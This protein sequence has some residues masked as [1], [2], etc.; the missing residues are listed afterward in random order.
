SRFLGAFIVAVVL[1]GLGAVFSIAQGVLKLVHPHPLD[2]L[3]VALVI[4]A[5]AIVLESVSLRSA[6]SAARLSKQR[7][8]SWIRLI[9]STRIPELAVVLIEDS[10]ALVGLGIALVAI[11]LSAITGN[12]VFDAVG[13][14]L[15]GTLLGVNSVLL[16]VEMASLLVGESASSDELE[17]LD[18]ALATTPSITRVVHLRAVHLG[19][20]ELLVGAK[21][22]FTPGLSAEAAAAVIDE[23]EVKIRSAVPSAHWVYIE[24]GRNDGR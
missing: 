7:S 14:L 15:I 9:R 13:S 3:A 23:A 10:G 17:R 19:P 12:T 4:L 20:E 22:I 16:G 18:R 24:P 5:I 2:H 1:F 8:Q 6:V 11:L 21:V